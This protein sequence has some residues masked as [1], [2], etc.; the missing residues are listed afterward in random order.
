MRMDNKITKK[1]INDHL[2]YDW[3][4]YLILLIVSVVACY[5]IFSQINRT[6]DYEDVTLFVSCYEA[7]NNDFSGRIMPEMETA[8]YREQYQST[9]GENVLR[10]V[11]IETQDPL[12]EN[13]GTMFQTHG[14]VTSDILVIGKTTLANSGRFVDLTDELLTNYLLPEGMEIDD[15]EYFELELS[16]GQKVRTGIKVS[17]LVHMPF[18]YDWNKVPSYKE[19]YGELEEDKQPDTEF[20]LVLNPSGVNIGKFGKKAKPQNAQALFCANRFLKYYH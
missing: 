17:N 14:M 10:E 8:T 9:F 2:E 12:G 1:R 13:Y 18:V 3:Y 6:R 20:Y 11:A 16:S 4:K 15:F 5:F 7:K 19:K